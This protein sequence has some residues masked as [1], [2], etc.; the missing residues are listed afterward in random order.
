MP[1]QV[2]DNENIERLIRELI[3]IRDFDRV[4]GE[5]DDVREKLVQLETKTNDYEEIKK[6]RE[7][8]ASRL[9]G[10][11]EQSIKTIAQIVE[12]LGKPSGQR[13]Y[14]EILQDSDLPHIIEDLIERSVVNQVSVARSR[15]LSENFKVEVEAQVSYFKELSG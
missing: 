12:Q 10:L 9:T 2:V 3:A 11:H 6:Q 14:D 13:H 8:A 1:G 7:D 5:L 4:K 15:E